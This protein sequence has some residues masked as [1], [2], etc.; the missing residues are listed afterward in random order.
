MHFNTSIMAY[1]NEN[2]ITAS[3]RYFSLVV[4]LADKVHCKCHV[5]STFEVQHENTHFKKWVSV[6]LKQKNCSKSNTQCWWT[7]H[8]YL[9]S[10][11]GTLSESK[12]KKNNNRAQK[13]VRSSVA[14]LQESTWRNSG[15]EYSQLV[16]AQ[17]TISGRTQLKLVRTLEVSVMSEGRKTWTCG[18]GSRVSRKKSMVIIKDRGT[19]L[20]ILDNTVMV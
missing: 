19:E 18:T 12:W 17:H 16:K 7:I 10:E 13:A 15:M 1:K 14:T 6:K 5:V 2:K 8:Q 20:V 11:E 4:R 9:P 3:A